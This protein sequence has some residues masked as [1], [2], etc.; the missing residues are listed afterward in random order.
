MPYE[1]IFAQGFIWR[2][3]AA[4]PRNLIILIGMWLLFFPSF[5]MLL[6]MFIGQMVASSG[7]A[8]QPDPIHEVLVSLWSLGVAGGSTAVFGLLL[9]KTTRNYL[10]LCHVK[11]E[12]DI[13]ENDAAGEAGAEDND[14]G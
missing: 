10:R 8:W 14:R 2:E 3:G 12:E 13:E 1:S 4:N 5:V 7:I 9:Y 11:E 6:M